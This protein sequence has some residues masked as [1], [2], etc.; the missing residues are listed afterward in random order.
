MPGSPAAKRAGVI[1]GLVVAQAV[2]GIA[3]LLMQVPLWLGLLHQAMAMVVLA[4]ATVHWRRLA[5]R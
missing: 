1:A 5:T 4:M 3:T 2:V